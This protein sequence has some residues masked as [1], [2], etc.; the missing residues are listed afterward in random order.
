MSLF[1][2]AGRL[3]E[4]GDRQIEVSGRKVSCPGSVAIQGKLPTALCYMYKFI[5]YLSTRLGPQRIRA[6]VRFRL[7][8]NWL[9]TTLSSGKAD[10]W[11]CPISSDES[12][13]G[14]GHGAVDVDESNDG[15]DDRCNSTRHHTDVCEAGEIMHEIWQFRDF[16]ELTLT[17]VAVSGPSA[18]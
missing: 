6:P 18:S 5:N 13:A 10:S 17:I 4:V 12:N 11:P 2:M 7:S 15:S 16:I 1:G 3:T 8:K 9:S 14:C